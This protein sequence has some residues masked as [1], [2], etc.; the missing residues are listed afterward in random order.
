MQFESILPIPCGTVGFRYLSFG[1]WFGITMVLQRIILQRSLMR[2]SLTKTN[3]LVHVRVKLTRDTHQTRHSAALFLVQTL[4]I[5]I[6]TRNSTNCR[7]LLRKIHIPPANTILYQA[8]SDQVQAFLL[9]T[10]FN[11]GGMEM[12]AIQASWKTTQNS[13]LPP[14]LSLSPLLSVYWPSGQSMEI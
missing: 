14:P 8:K 13:S 6:A 5:Q 1:C 4:F 3:Y 10:R 11:G 12:K 2:L 7:F 9:R